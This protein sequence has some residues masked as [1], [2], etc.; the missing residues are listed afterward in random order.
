MDSVQDQL[1]TKIALFSSSFITLVGKTIKTLKHKTKS[2]RQTKSK[3]AI[4][5][6]KTKNKGNKKKK[7]INIKIFTLK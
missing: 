4:K 3:T 5:R 2:N 7:K 6:Q 1:S